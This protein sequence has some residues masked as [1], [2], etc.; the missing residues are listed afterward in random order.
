MELIEL[1][2]NS[3]LEAK[4]ENIDMKTFYQHAGPTSTT[5]SMFASTYFCEQLFSLITKTSLNK[6]DL[7]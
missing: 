7:N 6:S 2:C 5:M 1:Q 4:F 3:L